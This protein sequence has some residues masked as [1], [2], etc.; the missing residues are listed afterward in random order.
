MAGYSQRSLV[1]KLGIK[2]GTR[3]AIV[4]PPRGYRA[5]LGTLPPGVTVASAV[6]GQPPFIH[7]LTD[8]R[9][10]FQRSLPKLLA[11]LTPD[12]ALWSSLPQKSSGVRTDVTANLVRPL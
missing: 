5:T 4:N 6:R 1:D 3:I 11:A 7:F 9:G 2:P 10:V 12:G 8:S